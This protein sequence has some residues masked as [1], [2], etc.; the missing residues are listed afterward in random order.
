[1]LR[2]TALPDRFHDHRQAP[3]LRRVLVRSWSAIIAIIMLTP[4]AA[5][6]ADGETLRLRIGARVLAVSANGTEITLNRGSDDG[7]Q[8]N[9]A[10]LVLH[11]NRTKTGATARSVD[12]LVRLARAT[13]IRVQPGRAVARL[14][15]R[16]GAVQVGDYAAWTTKIPASTQDRSLLRLAAHDVGLVARDNGKPFLQLSKLLAGQLPQ[17]IWRAMTLEIHAHTRLARKL[18]TRTIVGGRFHGMSLKASFSRTKESDLKAF[19]DFIVAYPGKYIGK[20]WELVKVYATWVINRTRS[21]KTARLKRQTAALIRAAKAAE[22]RGELAKAETKWRSVLRIWPAN[23]AGKLHLRRIE[24]I[25]MYRRTLKR[26]PKDQATRWKLA[27]ALYRLNAHDHARTLFEPLAQTGTRRRGA[28][29]Y[30]AYI[31]VR[32]ER[33]AEALEK[34]EA[35]AANRPDNGLKKW[36]QY[37]KARAQIVSHKGTFAAHMAIARIDEAEKAYDAAQRRL[38][39]AADVAT[40][41]KQLAAVQRAQIRLRDLNRFERLGLGLMNSV[42][43]HDLKNVGRSATALLKLANRH[44]KQ[45]RADKLLSAAA[46]TARIVWERPTAEV[47]QQARVDLG[48]NRIGALRDLA[49]VRYSGGQLKRARTAVN[50]ALQANHKSAYAHNLSGLLYL[51]SGDLAS[52]EREAKAALE[53]A[54]KYPWPRRT[55]ARVALARSKWDEGIRHAK[56]ALRLGPNE[57]ELQQALSNALALKRAAI[58]SKRDKRSLARRRLHALRLWLRFD[59]YKRADRTLE[60]LRGTPHFDAACWAVLISQDVHM[61]ATL[62]RKA[63]NGAEPSK[64]WQ[65]RMKA[66]VLAKLSLRKPTSTSR[67]AQL[68]RTDLARAY[69]HNGSYHRALAILGNLA[70]KAA[71]ADVAAMAADVANAARQGLRAKAITNRAKEAQARGGEWLLVAR[72]QSQAGRTFQA[73]GS[74]GDAASAAFYGAFAVAAEGDV[75]AALQRLEQVSRRYKGQLQPLADLDNRMAHAALASQHGSLNA[76][77]RM[78]RYGLRLCAELDQELCVAQTLLIRSQ[79]R[80]RDGRLSSAK[81]D[82]RAVFHFAEARRMRKLARRALYELANAE[83]VGAELVACVKHST[84]LLTRARKVFDATHERLGLMLLGAV[85]MRRG[86]AK[87]AHGRFEE[88]RLLGVRIGERAIQAMA[89]LSLGDNALDAAHDPVAAA[90]HYRQSATLWERLAEDDNLGRSRYGLARALG[91]QKKFNDARTLLDQVIARARATGRRVLLANALMERAWVEIETNKP[92]TALQPAKKAFAITASLDNAETLQSAHHVLGRAMT[93]SGDSKGGLRHLTTAAKI[94]AKRV[95]RSGGQDAQRGFLSYGRTRQVY[96]DAIDGLLKVGRVNEA[97]AL[98]ELSRDASLRK[99]F[100]P[101]RIKTHDSNLKRTLGGLGTAERQAEAARKQL[102]SERARPKAKQN[103]ARIAA[104]D[105]RVAESD[106]NVRR[107]LLRL[108]A[109]HQGLYQ[110]FAVDPRNLVNNRRHLPDDALVLAYFLAGDSL[111]IFTIAKRRDQ[112]HAFKVPLEG[113]DVAGL[114]TKYRRALNKQSPKSKRLGR[115]LHKL[116]IAPV[117]HELTDVRTLLVMPSGP[118]YFLPFHALETKVKGQQRYLIEAHRVAYLLSTTIGELEHPVRHGNRTRLAA[119]ANPDGTLPGAKVEVQRL[120][121]DAYPKASVFFGEKAD[122]KRV[123][124]E[125]KR[126]HVLHF[127]T[128]GVLDP[129]P[130]K[131]HLKMAKARLTVDDIAGIEFSRDTTLIVLSACQTA[132]SVG[133]HMGEGISIAEAF[134]TAGVPTLIASL[135]NVPDNATT[136]LMA[137]FYKHLRTGKNDT[138]SALRAAQLELMRL[139]IDGR[140]PYKHPRY[141]AGFELIGDYR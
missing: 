88:V 38:Q 27:Q 55:L 2:F 33:Y 103:A 7:L 31:L 100:D 68:T 128:H 26:K 117:A 115:K 108:K 125:A 119:F 85:A 51:L 5:Q 63:V 37:A 120:R 52:A 137:R 136:E 58:P 94:L 30:L 76:Q 96:R 36:I 89:L 43:G 47:L 123:L 133:K 19:V 15:L 70:R 46:N 64:G 6:A 32:E 77:H 121:R 4:N 59:L 110:A 49:W 84:R 62:L 50:Y 112:A 22:G 129:D 102:A 81:Q 25:A 60:M 54:P 109:R 92:K 39:Q 8:V 114:V 34:F 12:S 135:W 131:S 41:T 118:L 21:G 116:L 18:Y 69:V 73:I 10:G 113:M 106:A 134:A 74:L 86:D 140:R 13:V 98:I 99:M 72:L 122:K 127:A 48:F 44:R 17:E 65:T 91:R 24:H 14:R 107:L 67:A 105:K 1:M 78:N 90:V 23:R 101:G 53:W 111:Y 139:E 141:W 11:P 66:E 93:A 29:T 104:L 3:P 80:L 83:L 28:Q 71:G 126:H 138:L 95:S 56:A 35:L 130:L 45:K 75:K 87:A 42:R 82:A 79:L 9:E 40:T 57:K 132:V 97:M 16:T 20:D 124:K 61:P